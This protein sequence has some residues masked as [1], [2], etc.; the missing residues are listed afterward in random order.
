MRLDNSSAVNKNNFATLT[1]SPDS[2]VKPGDPDSPADST[3]DLNNET[4]HMSLS[5]SYFRARII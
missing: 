2:P 3:I 1:G 5:S 4:V